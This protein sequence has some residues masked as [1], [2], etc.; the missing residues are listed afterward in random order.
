MKNKISCSNNGCIHHDTFHNRCYLKIVC[1]GRKGE[2]LSF[3]TN[4]NFN[5]VKIICNKY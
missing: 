3:T 5:D 2:C 1:I 4:N